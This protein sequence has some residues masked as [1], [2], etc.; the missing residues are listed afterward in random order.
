MADPQALLGRTVFHYRIIE[1]LG[2]GAMGV[3]YKAEDTRLHRFVALKFLSDEIAKDPQAL[4]RFQREAQAASALNHPHICTIHDIGDDQGQHF[5]VMELLEGQTLKQV[6]SERRLETPEI[7]KLGLQ[8]A[9]ALSAA[10]AEGIVHHDV[11]PSNVFVT[12]RG[13]AKVLDFGLATFPLAAA[14]LAATIS[15]SETGIA[16]GTLPYMA[17]EQLCG[18]KGDARADLYS[19]GATLYEMAAGQLPFR[20]SSVA[21]LIH[22]IFKDPPLPPGRLNPDLPHDL[23]TIILKCLEKKQENR[24]QAAPDLMADLRRAFAPHAIEKSLVVLYFENLSGVKED[25]YLRDGMTEDIITE[26]SK[27]KPIR[28]FPRSAVLAHRD[29]PVIASEIARQLGASHVLGGTLR[30]SGNRLR[31]T[32]QLVESGTGH[33]VWAERYDREMKDI[34]EL[35]DEIAC[36]ISQALR[37]TLSP[38]EE[39]AIA[40]KPTQSHEAYDYYLRGRSYARRCTRSDLE[41]A[42]EMYGHAIA[43]DSRFALAHAGVG[44]ACGLLHDWHEKD[45]RWIERAVEAT[46]RARALEPDLPEAL[47]AYARLRWSQRNY[48]EAIRYALEAIR[49]KPDCENAYWTLGQAYFASDR[50]NEAA[51]LAERAVEICGADYNVHIPYMMVFERLGQESAARNLRQRHIGA[52]EVHLEQVPEDMR[53]RILLA[54]DHAFLGHEGEAIRQLKVA[55]ELC[56]NDSNILYNAACTYGILQ[57]RDESLASLKKAIGAGFVAIEYAERDPDLACLHG[58]PEFEKLLE[59]LRHKEGVQPSMQKGKSQP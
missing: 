36:S 58:H 44:I 11:K 31:I 46:E 20:E 8:I 37:I 26:L 40:S 9:D 45:P 18:E 16:A 29:K 35:Q 34:F 3:V 39:Q 30:R 7:L 12:R 50:W 41:L 4:A 57:K 55:I 47:A 54:N 13:D 15:S 52:L 19:L 38:Q 56:P 51:A 27:V 28:V 17:P 32:A 24:Y 48:D 23:E 49:H 43:L 59:E 21:A 6:I 5:I 14:D 42:I 53:A 1:K 2:G 25:E 33:S 10:H 22:A